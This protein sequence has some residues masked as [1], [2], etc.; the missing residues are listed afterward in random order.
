MP[1]IYEQHRKAFAAVSAYVVSRKGERVATVAFK[2]GDSRCSC[3]FHVIGTPMSK[4][5]ADGGG[6]DKA[7]AA[8][9]S[10]VRR[11]DRN[12]YP[13]HLAIVDEIAGAIKDEGRSWDA[14]LRAAGF[15]VWEAV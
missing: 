15:E 11:I 10:A 2:H 8:A 9:H 13:E 1:D 5:W 4:G 14:D 6:Y 3:F 12:A 7:S